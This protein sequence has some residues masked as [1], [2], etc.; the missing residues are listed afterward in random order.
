MPITG[1]T[2]AKLRG[3][4]RELTPRARA[5][6]L[7]ELERSESRGEPMPGMDL[8]IRELREAE[9]A[10]APAAAAPAAAPAPPAQPAAAQPADDSQ[11]AQLFFA[12]LEPFF[13]DDDPEHPHMGRLPRAVATPIWEWICRD[14]LPAETEA[15]VRQVAKLLAAR[16]RAGPCRPPMRS[17]TGWS[18]QSKRRFRRST[19]T[20]RTGAS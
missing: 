4:L 13:V 16:S 15:Y 10:T 5:M 1:Q 6:L 2:A 11:A 20:T 3:F 18:R 14:L 9:G 8:I 19:A 7:A 17:R 12:F